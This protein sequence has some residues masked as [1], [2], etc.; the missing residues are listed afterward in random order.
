MDEGDSGPH[1][2]QPLIELGAKQCND[3]SSGR[4]TL[5]FIWTS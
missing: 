5:F 2:P 4:V 3:L 1:I